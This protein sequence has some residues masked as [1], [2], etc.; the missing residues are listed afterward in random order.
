MSEYGGGYVDAYTVPQVLAWK[1]ETLDSV[2]RA[3]ASRAESL[4]D[5]FVSS[6][7]KVEQSYEY[8]DGPAGD[9]ARDR[10][11][12]D[13]SA[14]V[15]TATVLESASRTVDQYSSDL[16]SEIGNIRDK[17]AEAEESDY[18]L[19]VNPDG[20]VQ[21]RRSNAEWIK[22]W[23]LLW[24]PKLAA[25]EAEE[26]S[27]QSSIQ[28]SLTK[29]MELDKQ[30]SEQVARCLEDLS[31]DV[32]R[33]VTAVPTDPTLA[34]VLRKYQTDASEDGA[35]LW[36]SGELLK[37]IRMTNPGFEPTMMTPE[38]VSKMVELV[39]KNGPQA[40]FDVNDMKAEAEKAATD[41]FPD[42]TSDGHGDAFRHTYWNA[43]M[44]QKYGADWTGDF[45]T[46]HEGTGAN[47]PHREAMDLHNNELGRKLAEQ[48]PDATPEEMQK[49]VRDAIG[50]GD[51]I[52]IGSDQQINWSDKVTPGA[53]KS[54][55]PVDVPLPGNG[56]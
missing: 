22:E 44:T 45:T 29:V 40:I 20:A 11:T 9:A 46:A 38:E 17:V 7:R 41:Q 14:A 31:D 54:P 3:M 51:A 24:G 15:R 30:G 55:S 1:L 36:P 56:N 50:N 39:G 32:K 13:K 48:H 34:E 49:Y 2:G 21:S 18:E 10:A 27:L 23:G 43:L 4:E 28:G 25:K 5:D 42:S 19:F 52:V 37:A 47:S 35:T 26:L 12:E 33:G 53:T 16:R 6:T 8:W